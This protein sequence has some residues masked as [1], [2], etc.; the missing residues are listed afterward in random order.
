MTNRIKNRNRAC[1]HASV[2]WEKWKLKKRIR[3]RA[4]ADKMPINVFIAWFL[5]FDCCLFRSPLWNWERTSTSKQHSMWFELPWASKQ[6]RRSRIRFEQLY[7]V[8][9]GSLFSNIEYI[10]L[11][12]FS[13]YFASEFAWYSLLVIVVCVSFLWCDSVFVFSINKYYLMWYQNISPPKWNNNELK[14]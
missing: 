12:R 5:F 4:F 2:R 1:D 11:M 14:P 3:E 13:V 9:V 10:R 7:S 8:S 6:S